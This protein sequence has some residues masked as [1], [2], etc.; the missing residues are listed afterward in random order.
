MHLWD[1]KFKHNLPPPLPCVRGRTHGGVNAGPGSLIFTAPS[2]MWVKA[3]DMLM[4]KLRVAGLD[5]SRV[6]ALSGAGQ[7]GRPAL[8]AQH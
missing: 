3:L 4:D 8:T 1:D 7:V 2:I 5:F 6:A